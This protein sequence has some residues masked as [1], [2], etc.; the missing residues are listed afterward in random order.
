[1]GLKKKL[2]PKKGQDQDSDIAITELKKQ[3]RD[4]RIDSKSLAKKAE[5]S[6][7]NAGIALK[8]GERDR[9]RSYLAAYK[10]YQSE[11]DTNNKSI[12]NFEYFIRVINLGV[13]MQDRQKVTAL[14][15]KILERLATQAPPEVVAADI[16]EAREYGIMIEEAMESTGTDIELDH[17]IEVSD[18]ELD[19]LETEILLEAGGSMPNVPASEEQYITEFDDEYDTVS[20]KTKKEVKDEITKLREELNLDD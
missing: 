5:I 2:F 17:G 12:N 19:K 14:T 15:K 20:E 4:L 9:A 1:M 10:K 18:A 3:I 6:R 16:E 13:K 7:H 11:V 8:R